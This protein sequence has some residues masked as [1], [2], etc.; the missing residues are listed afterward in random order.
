MMSS[1]FCSAF[2]AHRPCQSVCALAPAGFYGNMP[3]R[4]PFN[5][6]LNGALWGASTAKSSSIFLILWTL[7]APF[8]LPSAPLSLF[9]PAFSPFLRPIPLDA[10]RKCPI[11]AFFPCGARDLVSAFRSERLRVRGSCLTFVK[12]RLA[13]LPGLGILRGKSEQSG[14]P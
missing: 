5:E 10:L 2:Y 14:S 11:F 12:R 13:L 4:P 6:P 7:E 9:S 3:V 1:C 8:F